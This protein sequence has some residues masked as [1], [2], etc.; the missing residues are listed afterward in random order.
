MIKKICKLVLLIT[1]N[2]FYYIQYWPT[3]SNIR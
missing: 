2:L 3:K 1:S